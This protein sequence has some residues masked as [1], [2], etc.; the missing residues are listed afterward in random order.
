MTPAMCAV[1]TQV[2][3]HVLPVAGAVLQPAQGGDQP[4]VQVGDADVGQ[5]VA[6]RPQAQLVDL[7]LRLVS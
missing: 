7:D 2:A 1:S 3:E 6:G 4:L 5:R